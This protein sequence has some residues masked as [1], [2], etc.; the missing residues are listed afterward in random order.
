M[1]SYKQSRRRNDD[2]AIV[3]AGLRVLMVPVKE[4]WGGVVDESRDG[5]T[6]LVCWK[7]GE[8]CLSYGGMSFKTVVAAKT[9][10]ALIGR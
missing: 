7:I 5:D 1:L 6:C 10:E 3:N 8:L 9:Q 4:G 2:L